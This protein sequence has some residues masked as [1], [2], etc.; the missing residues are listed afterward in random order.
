MDA[1][2]LDQLTIALDQG[3]QTMLAAAIVIMMFAIALGLK[4]EHFAFLRTHKR[5]FFG[6]LTAQLI[7]LPLMTVALAAILSPPPSIALGMIVVAACPGGNVSNFMTWG[8]R[9]DTAYSVSLTA[10]SSVIAA[11]WTPAAILLWSELYPPTADLLDTI[12]FNRISF[13]IQTTLML[14][15]P[16]GLGMLAAHRFP[17]AAEKIRKPLGLFG[18]GILAVVIIQGVADFW[19]ILVAGWML[20]AIPVIAHNA[21]AF[22]LGAATG[23]LL[24]ANEARRRSLTFEV[25]IQNAGL[26]VV[27]LLAQLKGLGGA[28]AIAAAWGV[29]H[30]FSGGVMITLFRTLDARKAKHL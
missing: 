7:G 30:F 18:G 11:L 13:V 8:A 26:A 27:L 4:P 22:A 20:I 1:E 14:A 2:T 19:P 3:A 5:L 9:G 24:G 12:E 16:L 17:G 28:A 6:G 10:G 29:W 15:A 25:G 23:R 21:C